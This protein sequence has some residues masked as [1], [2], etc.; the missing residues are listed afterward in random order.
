VQTNNT[1][2]DDTVK[3]NN[4]RDGHKNVLTGIE[5]NAV[6]RSKNDI[7][8]YPSKFITTSGKIKQVTLVKKNWKT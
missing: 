6:T 5:Y 8:R 3:R 2:H 4:I 7:K 1:R